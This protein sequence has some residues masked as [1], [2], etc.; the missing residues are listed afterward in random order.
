MSLFA[1][2]ED[3]RWNPDNES[4]EFTVSIGEYQGTVRLGRQLNPPL[5]GGTASDL[6]I[7]CELDLAK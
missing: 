2:P 1:F 4:V 6:G 7:A 5:M 3:A